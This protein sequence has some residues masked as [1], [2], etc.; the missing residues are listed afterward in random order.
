MKEHLS[1]RFVISYFNSLWVITHKK[2]KVSCAKA[3]SLATW[4]L[5]Q[6]SPKMFV[7]TIL[8]RRT[9]DVQQAIASNFLKILTLFLCLFQTIANL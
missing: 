6:P 8:A 5:G 9:K 3:R 7:Y 1:S 2:F 4:S